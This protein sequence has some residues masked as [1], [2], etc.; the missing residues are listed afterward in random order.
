MEFAIIEAGGRQYQVSPGDIIEIEKLPQ[1][2]GEK[3]IFDRVLLVAKDQGD[4]V[5]IGSP[6][7]KG[8]SVEAEV[9]AQSK[10]KKLIIFK[11]RP[12]KRYQKKQGHRQP[13][14]KIKI[15]KIKS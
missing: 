9:L 6:Y 3:V 1:K 15:L 13:F 8:I 11:K 7:L 4:S 14:T 10:W 5:E 12:K 2:L